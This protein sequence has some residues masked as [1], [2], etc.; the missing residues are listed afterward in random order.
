[1]QGYKVKEK[2][3]VVPHC[4]PSF[5]TQWAPCSGVRLV[6]IVTWPHR[7]VDFEVRSQQP[8]ATCSSLLDLP[9]EVIDHSHL[10]TKVPMRIEHTD[11]KAVT[12][13]LTTT[14]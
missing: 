2:T 1:M 7:S 12:K 5:K 11:V 9:L 14:F 8:Y 13:P 6:T 10:T 4:T 3:A